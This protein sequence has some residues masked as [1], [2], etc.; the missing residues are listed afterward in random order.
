MKLIPFI[1]NNLQLR[2]SILQLSGH[3]NITSHILQKYLQDAI[4]LPWSIG[5]PIAQAN[6]CCSYFEYIHSR[7]V[8]ID[9]FEYFI[10]LASIYLDSL[11]D[12][13]DIIAETISLRKIIDTIFLNAKRYDEKIF[14]TAQK[15]LDA[16]ANEGRI[17]KHHE[18]LLFL[19]AN[20]S[21]LP[22]NY[23]LIL[24][25]TDICIQSIPI[26]LKMEIN[27]YV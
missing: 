19:W 25:D 27:K 4:S 14:V 6:R 5:G 9:K 26:S 13:F 12:D 1:K 23:I 7:G 8:R 11:F 21:L 22:S 2:K 10:V 3:E 18:P 20:L 16:V 24:E 17:T 15:I